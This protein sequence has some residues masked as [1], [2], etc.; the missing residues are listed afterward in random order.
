MAPIDTTKVDAALDAI[1]KTVGALVPLVGTVG[2]LAR[3]F[4]GLAKKQGLD[5]TTF[6][7]EIAK[8]DA[9]HA[10]LHAATSEF[11][12]QFGGTPAA[13]PGD[14]ASPAGPAP[15]QSTTIGS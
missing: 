11:R 7:A 8:F 10:N 2:S 15:G 4:V 13:T 3:L 5:T 6:E 9:E 1:N 12:A 14:G